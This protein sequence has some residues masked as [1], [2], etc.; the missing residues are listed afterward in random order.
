M[1]L[2]DSS[3]FNATQPWEA[4]IIDPE[5]PLAGRIEKDDDHDAPRLF[6]YYMMITIT[7]DIIEK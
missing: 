1:P 3:P 4:V 2:V 5:C 7:P 6:E